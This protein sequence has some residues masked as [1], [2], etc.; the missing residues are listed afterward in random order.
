MN[1]YNTRKDV[2]DY[3]LK[4]KLIET[5][6]NYQAKAGTPYYNNKP[7]IIQD[8]WLWI[9]TYDEEKLLD[10]FNN[11]HGN[12]LISH[13][14][15]NQLFSTQSQYYAKYHRFENRTTEITTETLNLPDN[16]DFKFRIITKTESNDDEK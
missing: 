1:N 13:Y 12:A 11:N 3:L 5:C 8:A 9:M 10:A 2:T 14:L 7:D 16:Y 15:R 4:S 6:V